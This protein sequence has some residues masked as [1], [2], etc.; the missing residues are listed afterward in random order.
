MESVYR[1]LDANFNRAREG[2]RVVEEV[3]RFVLSDAALA[4]KVRELRHRLSRCQESFPAK[5]AALV[6]AR[7]V[8]GDVGSGALSFRDP[9]TI[10]ELAAANFK[11]VQEALRVLEEY[12]RLCRVKAPFQEMRFLAYALEQEITGRLAGREEAC[13]PVPASKPVDYTLYVITGDK[14]SRGRSILE[15]AREAISGGATVLQLREKEF[16]ARRLVEVGRQLRELTREAGVTFI[17]NDRVD[18]ALAVDADGVHLGQDDLPVEEARKIL[19]PGK[20]IG[21][22]THSVE[23]ALEA[24][25][26]GADYLGVGPIYETWTKEDAEAPLG[27]DILRRLVP[28]VHIPVVAIGGIK[29]HNAAE[30]VAA[31]ADGVAVIT[32]VVAAEDVAG[33]ARELRRVVAEARR[34]RP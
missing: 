1:I 19:G 17:V 3:A 11:R 12:A 24:Q 9:Q 32:A 13:R 20:I 21:V 5:G 30:A 29:A 2:L 8:E 16:S 26:R 27:P 23:Q 4:S 34:K 10:G 25:R 18:V 14:F 28:M 6:A 7:D 22:S 31:G 33:A 15:V